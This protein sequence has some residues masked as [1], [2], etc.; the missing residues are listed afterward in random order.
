[1]RLGHKNW[2]VLLLALAWPVVSLA[3]PSTSMEEPRRSYSLKVGYWIPSEGIFRNVLGNGIS[4]GGAF[5]LPLR[6]GR[7]IDF[8]I[9]YWSKSG[10]LAPLEY[11]TLPG[12]ATFRNSDIRLMPLSLSLRAEGQPLR[13]VRP[14]L[15]GGID[16][17]AIRE[18][19]TFRETTP[20]KPD[21]TGTN[22][23]SN[24]F[25]GFHF[26]GGAEMDL[27]PTTA[28]FLEGRVSIVNADTEGVDG[29]LVGGVSL[30]GV[31]ISAGLRFK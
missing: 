15:L 2:F 22:T 26:G 28:L 16:L 29:L 5:S 11:E 13:G 30:G 31:G 6:S 9:G 7:W 24:A 27:R 19:V 12:A 4:F 1:M 21:K 20:G 23:L 3:E 25:L 14:F 17:N 8:Q 10:D 18:E